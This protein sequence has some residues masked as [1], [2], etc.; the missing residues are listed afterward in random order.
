[1]ITL[2]TDYVN[3][4]KVN[5]S[6]IIIFPHRGQTYFVSFAYPYYLMGVQHNFW[7]VSVLTPFII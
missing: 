5:K 2:Y 1:M 7:D 4:K 3:K 6:K